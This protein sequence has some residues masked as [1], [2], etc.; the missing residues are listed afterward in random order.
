MV[1]VI[2]GEDEPAD[3][4]SDNKYTRAS[5]D[6][7]RWKEEGALAPTH[8]QSLYPYEMTFPFRGRERVIRGIICQVDLEPWGGSIVPHERILSEPVEDRLALMRE[9]RTNLSPIYAVFRGPCKP[10]VELQAAARSPT[11]ELVDELGV[12]HRMWVEG[13]SE[14]PGPWLADEQLLIADGHHRYTMAL[15]YRDEMRT[16][17]GPGPWDQVMMLLVDA[18]SEDPPV[19]PIHRL[20]RSEPPEPLDGKAVGSLDEMLEVLSD[21]DVTVGLMID[22]GDGLARTVVRLGGDPPTVCALHEQLL[23]EVAPEQLRFVTDAREAEEAVLQGTATVAYILP[24]TRVERIRSVVERAQRLPPK[25][26]FFWPK[27][28]TGLVM[29]PLDENQAHL[30]R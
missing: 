30:R 29:R 15:R 8:S 16:A 2:L 7:R 25:S 14:D 24:P 6:L 22:T 4:Q 27:P 3:D 19:L 11:C 1:R 23:N 20:A 13:D 28:R 9:V 18:A 21:D 17:F 5:R 10:L 12:R 26:T